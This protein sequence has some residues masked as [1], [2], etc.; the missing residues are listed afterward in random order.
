MCMTL[1]LGVVCVGKKERVERGRGESLRLANAT[2]HHVKGPTCSGT[3]LTTKGLRRTGEV[4]ISYVR[5]CR[6]F[7]P[8]KLSFS[9]RDQYKVGPASVED[10]SVKAL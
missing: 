9:F 1:Y 7:G 4:G 10:W 2:L 6:D 3:W 5:G 8:T